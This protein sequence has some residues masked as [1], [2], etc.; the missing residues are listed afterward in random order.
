MFIPQAHPFAVNVWICAAWEK[1]YQEGV[2]PWDKG[3]IAPALAKLI[4]EGKVPEGRILIPG[5]GRGVDIFALATPTRTAVGIDIA[6]SAVSHCTA[7]LAAHPNPNAHFV[8][9]DFFKFTEADLPAAVRHDTPAG[10]IPQFDAL[11][12]YTFLCALPHT[13]RDDWARRVTELVKPGGTLITL[14]YPLDDTRPVDD[15]P[16][17]PQSVARYRELLAGKFGWIE[18]E[19]SDCE[20]FPARAGREKVAVWRKKE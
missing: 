5:C 14:M 15:G 9:A 8:L 18:V 4:A 2:T 12:D 10:S 7:K 20:S 16:P 1:M 19:M 3:E 6:P 13:M 11:Y 17:F